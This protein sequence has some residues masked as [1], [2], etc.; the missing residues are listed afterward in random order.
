MV[1]A[2]IDEDLC[3]SL[4]GLFI[5]TAIDYG[6]IAS[7]AKNYPINYVEEI[8]FKYVAPACNYNTIWPDPV[9]I[10]LFDR[11]ELLDRINEIKAKKKSKLGKLYLDI[12]S[13]YLKIKFKPEWKILKSY[14]H[15]GN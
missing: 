1:N 15:N 8:L 4:S 13:F 14:Y 7:V 5:G 3:V 2:L 11:K 6:Y 12:C 10:Y 9:V